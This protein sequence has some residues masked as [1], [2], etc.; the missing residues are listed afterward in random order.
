VTGGTGFIGG[1]V[2]AELIGGPLWDDTLMIVRAPSVEEGRQR[3][4]KNIRKFFPGG[5]LPADIEQHQVVLAG[6]EDAHVIERDPRI[7]QITHVIHAAA[8][9]SFSQ[10]PKVRAVNVDASLA[11]VEAL[12]GAADIRR[13]VNVGT[14]WCVGIGS[15]GLVAEGTEP[16]SSEHAV[17][18]TASKI[19]F[20]RRMRS[21]Y[22]HLS[23]VTARPSIVVGHSKL[24]TLPSGSIYWVFR[25]GTLLDKFSCALDDRIDVVPV[26]WVAQALLRLTLK[27]TLA[28]DFY[29]LSAGAKAS[30]TIG[31]IRAAIDAGLGL[32]PRDQGIYE[33]VRTSDLA[34][35]V[36]ARDDLF[37]DIN[38]KLLA[39]ALCIYG[40]FAESGTLF[41]N[42]R[43]LAEGMTP[44]PPFASYA[45]RCAETAEATSIAGQMEDDFKC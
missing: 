40:R 35:H 11:F 7:Q 30:S 12:M 21:Q 26:D 2:L 13:F 23:F 38:R 36:F 15:H 34:R 25:A 5:R 10:T 16:L 31:E 22:P 14:A 1:A 42:D 9:A 6:L 24:G 20:E 4:L 8:L 45:A 43:T 17:P 28:S 33:R 44:P 32:T 18:Y 29:H 41:D 37:A 3:L 39:R 27:R 19:E